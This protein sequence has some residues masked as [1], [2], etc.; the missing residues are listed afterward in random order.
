MSSR[1]AARD[2]NLR[3]YYTELN[4]FIQAEE[5]DKAV[6]SA[7]KSEARALTFR[8]KL[9]KFIVQLQFSASHRKRSKLQ[10]AKLSL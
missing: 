10:H 9:S 6:K 7:N 4:K 2:Q 8:V 1:E 3:A 5:F